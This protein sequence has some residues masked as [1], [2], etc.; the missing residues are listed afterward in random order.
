MNYN[1]RPMEEKDIPK[2]VLAEEEIFGESLG[3]DLLLSEL[4]LNMMAYYLVLEIDN[5][6]SGYIG[7]WIDEKKAQ[8]INFY[9]EKKY[10]NLGFGSMLLEFVLEICKASNVLEI[11]LEVRESNEKAKRL[12]TKYGFKYSHK[13]K[14]Y[15]KDGEDALLLIK[16]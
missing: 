5:D 1:I 11:T 12:Y 2:I 10:Q 9:I 13:R 3:Y 4:K 15:Y 14:N 7:F 6:V 8:I 16:K